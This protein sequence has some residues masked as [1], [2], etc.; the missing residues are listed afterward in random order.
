VGDTSVSY[1]LTA[2]TTSGEKSGFSG[3]LEPTTPG[4][5]SGFMGNLEPAEGDGVTVGGP[6][7]VTVCRRKETE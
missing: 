1:T 7:S 6:S 4:S 5:R 2:P 3:T